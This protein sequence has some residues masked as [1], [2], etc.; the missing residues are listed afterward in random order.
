MLNSSFKVGK[1][2]D[3]TGLFRETLIR[4]SKEVVKNG[5]IE[6]KLIVV[7]LKQGRLVNEKG[8]RALRTRISRIGLNSIDAVIKTPKDATN[9]IQIISEVVCCMPQRFSDG[10]ENAEC[11]AIVKAYGPFKEAMKKRNI[12][13]M[14][15]V[16]LDITRSI[17]NG[18]FEVNATN[19][20]T[21]L[22]IEV[23]DNDLLQYLVE[24]LKIL[25]GI[26]LSKD[27]LAIWRLWEATEKTK[28][29]FSSTSFTD[30]NLPFIITEFYKYLEIGLQNLEEYQVC[31]LSVRVVDEIFRALDEKIFLYCDGHVLQFIEAVGKRV[32]QKLQWVYLVILQTHLDPVMWERIWTMEEEEKDNHDELQDYA[33]SLERN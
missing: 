13:D 23:F 18:V 27:R 21:F 33:C 2:D 22:G 11:E 3:D 29:E 19:G 28:I 9:G 10:M 8:Q 15:L 12:E 16:M 6:I 17:S 5:V 24:E 7:D 4:D 1:C 31:A 25:E 32:L 14:D 30:I 20:D 26:D